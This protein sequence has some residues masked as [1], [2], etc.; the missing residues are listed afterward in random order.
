MPD[1]NESEDEVR[2]KVVYERVSSSGSFRMNI[3]VIIVLVILAAVLVGYIL[4]H[5]HR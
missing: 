5:M 3:G 2:K 4:M 1:P